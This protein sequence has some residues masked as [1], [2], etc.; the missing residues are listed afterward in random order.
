MKTIFERRSIRK[1]TEEEVSDDIVKKMLKAGMAAP[2]AGNA[3]TWE[4]VVIDEDENNEKIPDIHP[5][6][7]MVTEVSKVILVCGNIAREKF[8]GLW[9][10]DCSAATQ[11]ILLEAT[12]NNLGAVWLGVYP[13]KERVNGLKKLLNLPENLIPFSIIPFGYPAEEKNIID[14]YDESKVHYNK[15]I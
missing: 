15:N 6:S 13:V 2:S 7:Q 12:S 8:E 4:F 11:N 3:Q 10:Q 14:R 5:Y 9:V 1:Y